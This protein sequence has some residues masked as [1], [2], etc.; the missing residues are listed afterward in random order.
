[1][2]SLAPSALCCFLPPHHVNCTYSTPVIIIYYPSQYC[3]H[4]IFLFTMTA[5]Q[6][7]NAAKCEILF[8]KLRQ[9]ESNNQ[10]QASRIQH[11]VFFLF[12]FTSSPFL[13]SFFLSPCKLLTTNIIHVSTQQIIIIVY[14]QPPHFSVV[15]TKT[16]SCFTL[17]NFSFYSS[18]PIFREQIL[19]SPIHDPYL[20][21]VISTCA[22]L[23]TCKTAKRLL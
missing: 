20:N 15:S 2:D 4:F 17:H 12:L 10:T 22:C 16:F 5:Q 18:V 11:H 21:L 9:P 3:A 6:S 14:Y 23:P 8:T 19:R 7:T 13:Y 1:M